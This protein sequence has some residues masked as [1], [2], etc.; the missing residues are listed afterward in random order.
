MY[1]SRF[2]YRFYF[3]V[4]TFS[5]KSPLLWN[6]L[7]TVRIS[8]ITASNKARKS[9]KVSSTFKFLSKKSELKLKLW[10]VFLLI[11]QNFDWK[12]IT[13]KLSEFPTN[14]VVIK[15]CYNCDVAISW[16]PLTNKVRFARR[17]TLHTAEE[18]GHGRWVTF[19][20]EFISGKF[21]LRFIS[22][23]LISDN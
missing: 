11:L 13:N 8:W 4:R 1:S 19:I 15:T 20:G 9:H 16:T 17:C 12:L 22:E 18:G 23:K 21:I 10:T 7:S 14:Y 6:W 3:C 5:T 2:C